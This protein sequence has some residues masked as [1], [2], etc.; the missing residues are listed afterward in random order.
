M[1]SDLPYVVARKFAGQDILFVLD[2]RRQPDLALP[3]NN[4]A[5]LPAALF[6][7]YQPRK[8]NL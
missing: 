3:E 5:A 8:K 1:P 2:G 4:L 6:A 7:A